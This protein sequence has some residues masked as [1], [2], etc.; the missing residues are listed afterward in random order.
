MQ[1]DRPPFNRESRSR[2]RHPFQ[3]GLSLRKRIDV[4]LDLRAGSIDVEGS[5]QEFG[6]CIAKRFR[7]DRQMVTG[8][9]TALA[10]F[11]VRTGYF[12]RPRFSATA[13]T[14]SALFS[15]DRFDRAISALRIFSR[16][17]GEVVGEAGED[18]FVV[19]PLSIDVPAF[20]SSF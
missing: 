12:S 3:A 15:G 10:Y 7:P 2:K 17:S 19:E 8:L 5:S 11:A 6:T 16:D 9:R 13:R 4:A 1:C 18:F 14:T 20:H